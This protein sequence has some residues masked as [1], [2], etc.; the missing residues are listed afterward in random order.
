[1][2]GYMLD[3]MLEQLWDSVYELH[4]ISAS[5]RTTDCRQL[6]CQVHVQYIQSL[7]FIQAPVDIKHPLKRLLTR[8]ELV[9][10]PE[11]E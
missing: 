1:M 9:V 3:Y 2:L 11:F 8:S 10:I 7:L 6:I 5:I 4:H